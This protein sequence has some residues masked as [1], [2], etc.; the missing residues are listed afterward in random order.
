MTPAGGRAR[1]AALALA[2]LGGGAA[3]GAPPAPLADVHVHYRW[4]QPE[5]D[6]PSKAVA[7]LE[8]NGIALAVA[9]GT[10]A[11]LGPVL[12]EAGGE[13]ILL[14]YTP[15]RITEDKYTWHQDETVPGRMRAALD[16]G[17]YAGIGE[18]HLIGGFAP[19]WRTPV[20]SSVLELARE[21]SLPLLL[22]VEFGRPEYLIDLCSSNPDLRI[23]WAHA[24]GLQGPG[25]VKR[26]LDACPGL[27]V[28]LSAR[29]PWRYVATPI[30]D[31][32]GRL[33]PGWR[34]LILAHPERFMVG[35]D[36][37]W[38]VDGLDRWETGDTGW[39]EMDRFVAFHRHWMADLPPGVERKVRLDN[40]LRFF[41]VGGE[42]RASAKHRDLGAGDKP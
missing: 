35:S 39:S 8:R 11:D 31:E 18:L 9:F 40:A 3:T 22:H 25:Q 6:D 38:P 15:Y 1:A 24:G 32:A 20:V 10:P 30:A 17:E 34:T 29:D 23:L 36:N 12:K 26:V 42:D 27:H 4:D 5:S 21:R 7:A 19:D 41:G 14:L 16:T 2:L 28:E 13:R 37:V 33:L